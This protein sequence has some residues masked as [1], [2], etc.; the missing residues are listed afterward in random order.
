MRAIMAKQPTQS[1]RGVLLLVILGMLAMFGLVAIAFVILTGQFRRTAEVT[2][3]IDI[4]AESPHALLENAF[5]QVVRG[6][7]N[8]ASALS[9]HSLLEDMYGNNSWVIQLP[10]AALPI[11]ASAGVI[12]FPVNSPP[13]SSGLPSTIG[14]V[15]VNAMLASRVGAILTP[16]DG[17][18]A[19][20]SAR[21]VYWLPS[22]N[23]PPQLGWYIEAFEGVAWTDVK[24]YYNNVRNQPRRILVN[25]VP[26]SGTGAG[27]P[28]ARNGTAHRRYLD[29]LS[30]IP[31]TPVHLY[32]QENLNSA[33]NAQYFPY[34][35]LP[36]MSAG[37]PFGQNEDY[38]IPDHQNMILAMVLPPVD[39][40]NNPINGL[41][42]VNG[43]SVTVPIPSLHRS[44]LLQYWQYKLGTIP[45]PANGNDTGTFPD[46]NAN[47]TRLV[48][49]TWG[50]LMAR[51]L[52]PG[53]F[54]AN[55]V[56]HPDFTGSNPAYRGVTGTNGSGFNPFWDG[57]PATGNGAWSWDVD[58][59]GDGSPDS[60]WV[61]LGM[62]VRA[63][64]DGRLY[65]PLF[66]VLCTDLDGRLNVNAHGNPQQTQAAYYQP[67][68]GVS[69]LYAGATQP[70][71]A[72]Q[73]MRRGAGFGPP[74]VN[75]YYL[76]N[77]NTAT[78][79]T[80]LNGR[81]GSDAM[82]WCSANSGISPAMANRTLDYYQSYSLVS[83]WGTWQPILTNY[84]TP[85]DY[86]GN[87]AVLLDAAGRPIWEPQIRNS[88]MPLSRTPYDVRIDPQKTSRLLSGVYIDAPYTP[89]ELERVLRLG[90]VDS[91]VLP[92]RLLLASG[93]DSATNVLAGRS[94]P[95]RNAVTT[96]SNEVPVPSTVN[97]PDRYTGASQALEFSAS[98]PA[99]SPSVG[100]L[101]LRLFAL[102]S[103]YPPT[104]W[105][106][107]V[108]S[109]PILPPDLLAGRRFN[110]NWAFGN[111]QDNT[112]L[113]GNGVVD[114]PQEAGMSPGVDY[115]AYPKNGGAT[116]QSYGKIFDYTSIKQ[117]TMATQVRQ[118]YAR[119]LYT[120]A[121]LVCD[122]VAVGKTV[123]GAGDPYA[124]FATGT[125]PAG[126]TDTLNWCKG[127]RALA[128]WAVNA[129]D[130]RDR[131][132]TCTVFYY[133]ANPFDGWNPPAQDY[134]VVIGVE[135]PRLL[136]TE[137]FA[138]HDRRTENRDDE[139][140]E[141]ATDKKA[142]VGVNPDDDKDFDQRLKP[143]GSLF[144]E[145][146]NASSPYDAPAGEFQHNASDS[147]K[148]SQGIKLAQVVPGTT[149]P[150][151]RI[152]LTCDKTTRYGSLADPDDLVAAN[153]PDVERSIYFTA[154]G[155]VLPHFGN[156]GYPYQ[157]TTPA[158]EILPGGY[159]VIGPG[160]ISE[161]ATATTY[162]GFANGQNKG[163]ADARHITLRHGNAVNSVETIPDPNDF[164][165][166]GKAMPPL[167]VIVNQP[168]RLNISEP[169]D[170][171]QDVAGELAA[172][173]PPV[174]SKV[175]DEPL[176]PKRTDLGPG[177]AAEFMKTT[178]MPNFR[179]A[180]LQRLA[181]PTRKY[182]IDP[183]LA[184]YNPFVTVDSHTIDLHIFNGVEGSGAIDPNDKNGK[185]YF[186]SHERGLFEGSGTHSVP[187]AHSATE[188]NLWPEEL[189]GYLVPANLKGL[190]SP[191]SPTGSPIFNEAWAQSL[192]YLNEVFWCN[193]TPKEPY[194]GTGVPPLY[195][196]SPPRAFPWITW[197]DRPYANAYEL[198]MVPRVRSSLLLRPESFSIGLSTTSPYAG[199]ADD[200]GTSDQYP[201]FHL[202]NYMASGIWTGG[203]SSPRP[204]LHRLLEYLYVPSRF[205]ETVTNLSPTAAANLPA[206]LPFHPPFNQL[207]TCREPGK[208]N[209]N[210]M[211]SF[212]AWQGLMD[213]PN[214][215]PLANR[216]ESFRQFWLTKSKG[217]SGLLPATTVA[218]VYE[219]VLQIPNPPRGPSRFMNPVRSYQ[220]AYLMSPFWNSSKTAIS[221][222]ADSS[223]P[224]T[225][226]V[227]VTMMR[228][229]PTASYNRPVLAAP[230]PS[231]LP[232][233]LQQDADRN[234]Y[235]R[236]HGLERLGSSVTNRSSVYAVWITVGYFEAQPVDTSTFNNSNY[237]GV[238]PDGVRLGKEIGIDDGNVRRHRAF[239]MFD[240]SV[241]M[242]FSRGEDLNMDKGVL[243]RRFIE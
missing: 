181:D 157:P 162:L 142:K 164:V 147:P 52:G 56:P 211:Y 168:R 137:T 170:A 188:T 166:K 114:D 49:P 89:A 122:P 173:D 76:L 153:Q 16:L 150:V 64:P 134:N 199:G 10:T 145:L 144:I 74:E 65:K 117:P 207:P 217:Y 26:F 62:P 171:Y 66:A 8:P 72:I 7:T 63:L 215:I 13:T 23:T 169:T 98:N 235:F 54:A 197:N 100:N 30:T 6:S 138:F 233:E 226:E 35:G 95:G 154:K 71:A 105:T 32:A 107:M 42:G 84:G 194:G 96:I 17:P 46:W 31:F 214:A 18:A 163:T 200:L 156:D 2:R 186:F 75:L 196:G 92:S 161:G 185:L 86:Y 59:D 115:M 12:F 106:T 208:I 216:I 141:P 176:D 70:N 58:N 135:R 83:P 223:P 128:Q 4:Q 129:V 179:V 20:K 112:P 104:T 146:Y 148:W 29:L 203:T 193:A 190:R 210:T 91:N 158:G 113:P 165:N 5:S 81:Y 220:G 139:D 21:I 187:G 225:R 239:Y 39:R 224:V 22:T 53:Y 88:P 79:A 155:A 132:S 209:V 27:S 178:T 201:F 236:Y 204:E 124:T 213:Y 19:G 45:I 189:P 243:L 57:R 125:L 206:N 127:C 3:R 9:V 36:N 126:V 227:N 33:A 87:A 73:T 34:T 152:L 222:L 123:P 198:L 184:D 212:D 68:T 111:G 183:K 119:W 67:L 94:A 230:L 24:A 118:L 121:L 131:D 149:E 175:F 11:S 130:F 174:F 234:A 195:K 221:P 120:L 110:L 97:S 14:G 108:S 93:G 151:W 229:H 90:D 55:A 82:P 202:T 143:E 78:Y 61:D 133:D 43:S 228:E 159:A 238:Y 47:L 25:G 192:G 40:S 1:R 60:V 85:P 80:L 50:R 103:G 136:I 37:S 180:H 172:G 44:D 15:D 237:A 191:I 160:E 218:Q 48:R 242:G 101:S 232:T 77:S 231:V 38:D 28:Y 69:Y 116:P 140:P 102:A 182:Q 240:R 109:N 167:A 177:Q 41:P 205:V 51:P 241:P 219:G 99:T